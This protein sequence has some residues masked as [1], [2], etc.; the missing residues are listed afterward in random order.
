MITGVPDVE[1]GAVQI[2]RQKVAGEPGAVAWRH[3]KT[4]NV[5]S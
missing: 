1:Q 4:V 2:R 5:A 3:R